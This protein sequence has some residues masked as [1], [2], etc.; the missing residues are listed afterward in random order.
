MSRPAGTCFFL[1]TRN[2]QAAAIFAE[3]I[4]KRR[5]RFEASEVRTFPGFEN[6][7]EPMNHMDPFDEVKRRL[8]C[9]PFVWSRSPGHRGSPYGDGHP[10]L[11][12]A[13]P[14]LR[15]SLVLI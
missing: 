10:W 14:D 13:R 3:G 5:K 15:T 11:M 2:T 7:M 8:H 9:K 4:H 6:A 1:C 12:V